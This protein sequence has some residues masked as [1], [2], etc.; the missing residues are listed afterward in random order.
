M[1]KNKRTKK[2]SSPKT[3]GTG[4]QNGS[5]LKKHFK[6]KKG[7]RQRKKREKDARRGQTIK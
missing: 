6:K 4:T 1:R 3:W 7:D 2:L 5:T